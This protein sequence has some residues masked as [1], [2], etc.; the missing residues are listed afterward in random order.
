[1]ILM[2]F[3]L[4]LHLLMTALGAGTPVRFACKFLL[5]LAFPFLRKKCIKPFLFALLI[6]IFPTNLIILGRP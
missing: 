4:P 2:V 5:I 3:G 6:F 1:L